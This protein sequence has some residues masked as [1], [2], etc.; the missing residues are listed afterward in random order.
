MHSVATLQEV[1]ENCERSHIHVLLDSSYCQSPGEHT[2]DEYNHIARKRMEDENSV[3]YIY[4]NTDLNVV[5]SEL[6]EE[7]SSAVFWHFNS[8]RPSQL[9]AVGNIILRSFQHA[10]YLVEWDISMGSTIM[11]VITK[12]SLPLEFIVNDV[13][14][15]KPEL[16]DPDN[17]PELNDDTGSDDDTICLANCECVNC[18]S[19][20]NDD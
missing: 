16:T 3:G 5:L 13:P 19:E 18:Q 20:E 6:N 2:D 12:E 14:D 17:Y 1:F 7:G 10:G 15:I 4:S 9:S 11:S 8:R